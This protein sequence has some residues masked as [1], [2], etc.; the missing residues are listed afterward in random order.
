MTYQPKWKVIDSL[1]YFKDIQIPENWSTL[2]EF[3]EWWISLR[4]PLMIPYD[5]EVIRTDDATAI[6]LFR[7]GSYQIELYL[8]FPKMVVRKHSHPRMEVIIMDLG[9]GKL[10]PPTNLGISKNWGVLEKKILPGQE[11]GGDTTLSLGN[12]KCFLA[13]Q[14]WYN[15]EEMSSAAIQWKGDTAGPVQEALIKSKKK[16]AFVVSGY[17]DINRTS[18]DN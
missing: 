11:H 2:E 7:K 18:E 16:N 1:N 15:P 12:G 8:E 13:F 4:M 17:A 14:K 6:C 5:A 3:T 9:G 10:S